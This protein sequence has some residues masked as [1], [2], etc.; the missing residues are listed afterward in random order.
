MV[1]VSHRYIL[2]IDSAVTRHMEGNLYK[3][4]RVAGWLR[5]LGHTIYVEDEQGMQIQA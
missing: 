3:L 1:N 5:H 2:Y 4:V